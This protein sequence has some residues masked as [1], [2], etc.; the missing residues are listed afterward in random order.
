MIKGNKILNVTYCH[1]IKISKFVE[2]CLPPSTLMLRSYVQE[3]TIS[4]EK[5]K[6]VR[7]RSENS[8]QVISNVRAL[9]TQANE[10]IPTRVVI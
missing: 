3:A 10:T 9:Y 8:S 1:T 6:T 7:D 4:I 5:L 2:H